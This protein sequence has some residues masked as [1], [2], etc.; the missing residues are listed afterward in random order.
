[1]KL[2]KDLSHLFNENYTMVNK[3]IGDDFNRWGSL[4]LDFG[5]RI[6][7]VKMIIL[8]RL[9]YLFQSLPV[10]I[11]DTQ[12]KAWDKQISR[13][14]WEGKKPRIRYNTLQLPREEGGMALPCL[15]D[16]YTAAQLSPLILWCNPEYEA[17][18][19]DIEISLLGRPVQSLLGCPSAIGDLPDLQ[20]QWVCFSLNVWLDFV[21]KFQIQKEIKI[22]RWPAYDP[23]FQPAS[24]DLK[25]RQWIRYGITSYSSLVKDGKL[26]AFQAMSEKYGLE[27]KDVYRHMQIHHYYQNEVKAQSMEEQSGV[28]QMFIKAYNSE[29]TRRIIGNLYS[30]IL[31]IKNYSTDYI[32]QKWER[33]LDAAISQEEWTTIIHTQMSTTNSQCWR[34]FCWKNLVRFFIT[35]K[36]KSKQTG[37]QTQCWRLCGQLMADHTHI[38]WSCPALQPFWTQVQATTRRILGFDMDF[39]CLSFYLG[40]IPKDLQNRDEYLLKIFMVASK[41][42]IT[43]RWLLREP[44]TLNQWVS[45]V[46]DILRLQKEKGKDFWAKW[47]TYL[48]NM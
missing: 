27:R 16:F 5:S 26:M 10:K 48:A 17:N 21:K 47:V 2:T 40:N 3:K 31:L 8:P 39:S 14:I 34:N 44:P 24:L 23:D 45:I 25:Y 37:H 4:P 38:F 15:R 28:T 20:N 19:K 33:E 32:K 6:M 43:R 41:K 1:M 18:W 30:S 36:I 12:F 9:L 29:S 11:S 22:L 46:N 35:P 13:F 42:A 7:T